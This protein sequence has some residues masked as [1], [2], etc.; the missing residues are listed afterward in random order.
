MIITLAGNPIKI[1]TISTYII[2]LRAGDKGNIDAYE[3]QRR[4]LHNAIFLEAGFWDIG[5]C[6]AR[7]VQQGSEFANALSSLLCDILACPKEGHGT[8]DRNSYC[9]HCG[10]FITLEDNLTTLYNISVD[11][12]L[13]SVKKTKTEVLRLLDGTEQTADITAIKQKL[14]AASAWDDMLK[15]SNEALQ[16]LVKIQ[17]LKNKSRMDT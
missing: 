10:K 17:K 6:P 16:E 15:L 8:T 5:N 14:E 12:F 3:Q 4:K 13:D 1:E 11:Q 7:V 9:F 2:H